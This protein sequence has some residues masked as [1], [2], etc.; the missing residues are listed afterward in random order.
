[1]GRVQSSQSKLASRKFGQAT[2]LLWAILPP[3]PSSTVTLPPQLVNLDRCLGRLGS[4]QVDEHAGLGKDRPRRQPASGGSER[5]RTNAAI[6]KAAT[7]ERIVAGRSHGVLL[8]RR[9]RGAAISTA[10]GRSRSADIR[11]ERWPVRR[12]I[13]AATGASQKC[14]VSV[15]FNRF[16]PNGS[17]MG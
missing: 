1:S 13:F 4:D 9:W 7:C 17:W 5:C 10:G 15:A 8:N 11:R 16:P 14:A 6:T 3:E 12:R 2:F